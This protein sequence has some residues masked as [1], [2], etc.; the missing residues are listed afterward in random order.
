V[1]VDQAGDNGA[2]VGV[3]DAVRVVVSTDALGRADIDDSAAIDRDCATF[4]HGPVHVLCDDSPVRDEEV[5]HQNQ[6]SGSDATLSGATRPSA[7]SSR[8]IHGPLRRRT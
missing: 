3:D 6:S 8:F 7:M 1:W 2:T 5:R 4:E